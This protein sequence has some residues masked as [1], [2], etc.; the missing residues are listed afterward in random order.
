[1]AERDKSG[2]IEFASL[3][4]MARNLGKNEGDVI[5]FVTVSSEL[6]ASTD[7]GFLRMGENFLEKFLRM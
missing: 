3:T 1:V 6:W 2:Y 4:A 7:N 5:M